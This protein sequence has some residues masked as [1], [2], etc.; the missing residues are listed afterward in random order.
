[1][2]AQ[3]SQALLLGKQHFA[4]FTPCQPQLFFL[5]FLHRTVSQGRD[6]FLWGI[7]LTEPCFCLVQE[8]ETEL[9]L[10]LG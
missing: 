7:S 4:V 1:M 10:Q 3:I 8:Q 6:W 2:G 9:S 5:A